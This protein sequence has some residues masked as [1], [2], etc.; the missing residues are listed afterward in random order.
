MPSHLMPSFWF[1]HF[2]K[3]QNVKKTATQAAKVVVK[4]DTKQEAKETKAR[5]PTKGLFEFYGWI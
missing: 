2:R 3:D 5:T 4:K 1:Q